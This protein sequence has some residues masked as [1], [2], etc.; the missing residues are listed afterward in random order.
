MGSITPKNNDTIITPP[1]GYVRVQPKTDKKL[2]SK[3]E[4]GVEKLLGA[5]QTVISMGEQVAAPT[6]PPGGTVYL[7]VLQSDRHVYIKD[8]TGKITDITGGGGSDG[9]FADGKMPN[10]HVDR[11]TSEISFNNVNRKFT[12]Q[13]KTPATEFVYYV[14]GTKYIK[15]VAQEVTITDTEGTWFIYFDGDTLTASQ[16][17]WEFD[18]HAYVAIVYWDATNKVHIGL[19]D[20]RHDITMDWSTHKLLHF[21]VGTRYGT[22]LSIGNYTIVGDGSLDAH[23][24]LSVANGVIHDEDLEITIVHSATPT[25]PFEQYLTTIAKIPAYYRT[26]ANGYW[27]KQTASNFPVINLGA[28]RLAWNQFTGGAWQQTEATDNYFTAIWLFATTKQDEPI[29]AIQGQREDSSLVD[30]Q[31]NNTYE[32]LG[33]GTLPFQEMKLIFRLIFRT[34]STFANT[35][36]AAL[37]GIQDLRSVS[38][39]P[40]G[41]YVATD[42]NVLTNRSAD[43]SH[44][45]SAIAVDNS[46]MTGFLSS[47]NDVQD[48]LV[49]IDSDAAAL[50]EKT[51]Y[52]IETFT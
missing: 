14:Q 4:T 20:E 23:A 47:Y 2:Y 11:T 36:K 7:Y 33:L 49:K 24:Q 40:A 25:N 52:F 39:L 41:T 44:P 37:R 19:S 51:K 13:K 15:T 8:S 32:S 10:G 21:T 30:A 38:N 34:K 3:D 18:K 28:G 27:R 48:M 42:H 22:G 43:N 46:A 35:V 16:T 50:D 1:S 26:G 9:I 29:M 12:I 31:N 6:T 5:Y 45:A 17:P